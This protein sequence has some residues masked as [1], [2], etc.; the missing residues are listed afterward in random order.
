MDAKCLAGV[1]L[2]LDLQDRPINTILPLSL[3]ALNQPQSTA[4]LS[5]APPMQC[6]S[7]SAVSLLNAITTLTNILCTTI[8]PPICSLPIYNFQFC[9]KQ[10]H[11]RLLLQQT[12]SVLLPIL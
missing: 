9:Y 4:V 10:I 5:E 6:V 12:V 2:A 11:L 3:Q 7:M 8:Y 1:R